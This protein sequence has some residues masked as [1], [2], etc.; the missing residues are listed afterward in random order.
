MDLFKFLESFCIFL[1]F[2]FWIVFCLLFYFFHFLCG[3][4]DDIRACSDLIVTRVNPEKFTLDIVGTVNAVRNAKF[5]LATQME[6][7]DK[8]I[9]IEANERQAREKLYE[10]RKQV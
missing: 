9:E 1:C 10:V 5:M 2:I 4:L 3:F 7:V 6:Y 8:Q